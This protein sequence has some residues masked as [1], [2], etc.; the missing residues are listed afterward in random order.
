MK[1]F[2]YVAKN[3]SFILSEIDCCNLDNLHRKKIPIET[4]NF[5]NQILIKHCLSEFPIYEIRFE[6][7]KLLHSYKNYELR[8]VLKRNFSKIDYTKKIFEHFELIKQL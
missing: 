7:M 4:I 5:V 8:K 3:S 6:T 2:H 1:A